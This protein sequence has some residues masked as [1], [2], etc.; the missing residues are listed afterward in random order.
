MKI[1]VKIKVDSHWLN[2]P[3][4]WVCAG[5]IV[6]L[7]FYYNFYELKKFCLSYQESLWKIFAEIN[8]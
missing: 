8:A 6:L 3:A 2:F 7:V 1:N 5:E 4:I